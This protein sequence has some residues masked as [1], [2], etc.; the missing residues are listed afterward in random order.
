MG[1][2]TKHA[3][4]IWR[5]M[6]GTEHPSEGYVVRTAYLQSDGS[7][8]IPRPYNVSFPVKLYERESAAQKFADKLNAQ[9]R[10]TRSF[11]EIAKARES[12]LAKPW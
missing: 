12:D 2:K 5:D 11:N 10:D 3:V 1:E 8:W 9:S 7:Y 6:N 4:V